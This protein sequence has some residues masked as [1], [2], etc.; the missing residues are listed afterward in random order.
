MLILFS[1]CKAIVR[2]VHSIAKVPEY[3]CDLLQIITAVQ[4]SFTLFI[5]IEATQLTSFCC[6]EYVYNLRK[7]GACFKE[8]TEEL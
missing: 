1:I 6:N 4:Q 8:N 2:K 3:F 5:P 7:V